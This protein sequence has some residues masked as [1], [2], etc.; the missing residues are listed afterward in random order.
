MDNTNV[1]E[2]VMQASFEKA[3]PGRK[4]KTA[5][6]GDVG[7]E[8]YEYSMEFIKKVE[9]VNILNEKGQEGWRAIKLEGKTVQ[10]REQPDQIAV[11]V[12]GFEVIFERKMK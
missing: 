10:M 11:P 3:K 6:E 2:S 7:G 9:L 12:Q 8:R 4:K 1:S 5:L